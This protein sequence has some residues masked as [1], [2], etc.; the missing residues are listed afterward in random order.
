VIELFVAVV[1]RFVKDLDHPSMGIRTQAMDYFLVE[2]EAFVANAKKFGM[3]YQWIRFEVEK[4]VK[5]EGFRKKKLV[6][7]LS[8]KIREYA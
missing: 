3:P 8:K 1:N 7:N 6:E 5:E 4:I 2:N